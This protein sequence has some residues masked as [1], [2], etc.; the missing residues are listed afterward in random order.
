ML[1]VKAKKRKP[2]KVAVSGRLVAGGRGVPGVAVTILAGKRGV[3]KVTTKAA[4]PSRSRQGLGT[5]RFSASVVVTPRKA[6]A[7]A[8][9]FA[10]APVRRVV[11]CGLHGEERGGA[12]QVR[13]T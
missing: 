2:G 10:P 8:P 6:A 3:G 11:G 5:A 1:T 4:A 12:R 13:R 7:C 9:Y